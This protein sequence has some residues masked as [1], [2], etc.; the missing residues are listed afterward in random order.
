MEQI[1]LL[2]PKKLIRSLASTLLS[3]F[4]REAEGKIEEKKQPENM[5]KVCKS[6]S[7]ELDERIHFDDGYNQALDDVRQVVEDVQ[8]KLKSL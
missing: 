3:A 4:K 8:E 6:Y 7:D 5:N 1:A 2:H